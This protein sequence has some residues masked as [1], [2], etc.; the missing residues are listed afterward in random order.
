MPW[1][2]PVLVPDAEGEAD[3]PPDGCWPPCPGWPLVPGWPPVPGCADDDPA[4][5]ARCPPAGSTARPT[6]AFEALHATAPASRGSTATSTL[7]AAELPDDA[8]GTTTDSTIAL[9]A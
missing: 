5:A 9:T 8:D 7:A 3:A 1:P 6:I 2:Q 4:P